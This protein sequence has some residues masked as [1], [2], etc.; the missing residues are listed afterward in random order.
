[1]ILHLLYVAE[2]FTK[3]AGGASSTVNT[4]GGVVSEVEPEFVEC[5]VKLKL[6]RNGPAPGA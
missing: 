6:D 5:P 2:D 3:H 4:G 1:M